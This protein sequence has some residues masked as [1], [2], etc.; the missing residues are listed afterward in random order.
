M[1][2]IL[3]HD[4]T[5]DNT[6]FSENTNHD[7]TDVRSSIP[8]HKGR[9]EVRALDAV[10]SKSSEFEGGGFGA[11][12]TMYSMSSEFEGGGV[13]AL[14][15]VYS[16]SSEVEN[17][18]LGSNIPSHKGRDGARAVDTVY[19]MSSEFENIYDDTLC[20]TTPLA[21]SVERIPSFEIEC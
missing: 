3:Q 15:T 12:D 9:D 16:T 10:Y 6:L 7:N 13:R 1:N 2:S 5:Y 17:T 20:M 14:D 21:K 11:L 4:I 8:R 19:N 18:N